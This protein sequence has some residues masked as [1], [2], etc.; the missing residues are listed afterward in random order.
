M[1]TNFT[2]TISD[3]EVGL[4][5]CSTIRHDRSAQTKIK[6][7]E[8]VLMAVN[9]SIH[10]YQLLTSVTDVECFLS[11]PGWRIQLSL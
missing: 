6:D 8:G 7:E 9:S 1:E 4:E 10:C 2:S 3:P 11:V 5:N